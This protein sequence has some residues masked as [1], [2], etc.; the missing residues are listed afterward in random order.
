MKAERLE[1]RA[2]PGPALSFVANVLEK[3]KAIVGIVPGYADHADRYRHVQEAW[4]ERGIASVAIDLRGHGRAEG[5]RG[6]CSRFEEFLDDV[7]ELERLVQDRGKGAPQFLFGHSFGGLVVSRAM[8]ANASPWKGVLLSSP[9]LAVAMKVPRLK[10]AAGK[11]A[12]AVYPKLMMPSEIP[13]SGL[14]HDMVK[15]RAYEEDP[16]VFKT[17]NVRWFAEAQR[18]QAMVLAGARSIT[19]P[20]Y[21]FFGEADP[22]VSFATGKSF[23]DSIGSKDKTF[24]PLPKLLHETLNEPEWRPIAD[25]AATWMLD[26]V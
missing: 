2:A 3:P 19:L 15:V 14:T 17:V 9:F 22:I 6:S 12:S 11:I 16:L 21:M 23:F 13:A 7:G 1:R 24:V 26:H 10:R 18:A 4:G 20:F 5:P 8:L 25:G